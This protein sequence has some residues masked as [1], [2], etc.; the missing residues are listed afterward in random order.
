MPNAIN[1]NYLKTFFSENYGQFASKY[2]ADRQNYNINY[3]GTL[4]YQ[5]Y[6]Q[7]EAGLQPL[8][9][10]STPYYTYQATTSGTYTFVV[11]SAYS[12]YKANMSNGITISTNV[13]LSNPVIPSTPEAPTEPSTPATE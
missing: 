8:G 11:K 6:L 5:V 7:T 2:L 10:T 13:T 1:D 4:G 12:I 3:I 9:F